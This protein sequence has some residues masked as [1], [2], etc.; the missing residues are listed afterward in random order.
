MVSSGLRAEE[1]L[2]LDEVDAAVTPW[3]A[4]QN[5]PGGKNQA[6][7]YAVSADRGDGVVRA[8]RVVLAAL[9]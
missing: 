3:V 6:A 8:G 2:V 7:Q 4:A 9:R 1:G 5:A